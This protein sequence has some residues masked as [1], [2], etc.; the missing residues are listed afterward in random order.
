MKRIFF[1]LL[2][3]LML[4]LSA[5]SSTVDSTPTAAAGTPASVTD[6]PSAAPT[7]TPEPDYSA[8]VAEL[9]NFCVV[10]MFTCYYDNA[11]VT[12]FDFD[13]D[14]VQDWLVYKQADDPH[15]AWL[16]LDGA[17]PAASPAVLYDVS[18]AGDIRILYSET[19]G[20]AVVN[21]FYGSVGNSVDYYFTFDG[22]P[23]TRLAYY[24]SVWEHDDVFTVVRQIDGAD[25]CSEEEWN[26][27]IDSLALTEPGG[28][29]PASDWQSMSLDLPAEALDSVAERLSLLPIVYEQYSADIDGDGVDDHF[30]I[31]STG[32]YGVNNLG[33]QYYMSGDTLSKYDSYAVGS[34]GNCYL[35]LRSNGGSPTAGV[36]ESCDDY[37]SQFR[38]AAFSSGEALSGIESDG[39][40]QLDLYKNLITQTDG[41]WLAYAELMRPATVSDEALRQGLGDEYDVSDN[42]S[43]QSIYA[44]EAGYIYYRGTDSEP[45]RVNAMSD[46]VLTEVAAAGLVFIPDTAT[47]DDSMSSMMF[48]VVRE[49]NSL[50]ELFEPPFEYITYDTID[51]IVT[52]SGGEISH[53]LYPYSP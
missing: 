15:G 28:S 34:W 12:R 24:S 6:P 9:A 23:G 27:Y 18:A 51:V 36:V 20:S 47:Y 45:W 50:P 38:E 44:G 31:L 33:E 19:L 39:D 42:G 2:A 25:D 4:I 7:A 49:V 52:V 14:G 11:V 8:F 40:Y 32:A 3:L 41:G 29:V 21:K 46:V 22:V 1:A 53:I 17:V 13:S 37:V 5:C 43:Y 35:L 30:F 48:G 10:N 26:A 16:M